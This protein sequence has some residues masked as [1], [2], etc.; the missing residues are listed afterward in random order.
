MINRSIAGHP[1][2]SSP[3]VRILGAIANAYE[4]KRKRRQHSVA[5][6]S[7]SFRVVNRRFLIAGISSAVFLFSRRSPLAIRRF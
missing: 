4:P 6:A 7:G 3:I 2:A 1:I 5:Y